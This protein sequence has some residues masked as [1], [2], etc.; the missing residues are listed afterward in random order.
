MTTTVIILNILTN[1]HCTQLCCIKYFS[2][3]HVSNICD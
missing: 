1:C 3:Y 2:A